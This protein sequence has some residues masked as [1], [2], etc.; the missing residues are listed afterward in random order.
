MDT[1][2][3]GQLYE[4]WC[5]STDGPLLVLAIAFV[6]VLLLPLYQPDLPDA[7]HGA[8]Q[9]ANV[10]LWLA[11]GV[12][13]LTRLGLAPDRRAFARTHVPDLLM[14]AVPFLRPLRLLRVIGLLGSASRRAAERRLVQTTAYVI[15]GVLVLVVVAGGLVLDAERGADN[16]NI[17]SAQDALWWASTTVTTVGYGD[18]FPVTGQGRLVAVA[19]MVGGIALLGVVTASVAAWFVRRFT[20]LET[21]EETAGADARATAEALA[22]V[23]ERLARIEA[24]LE[25]R[26]SG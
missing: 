3:R 7:A 1:A 8:L 25:R 12:D 20:A 24:A 9:V 5:R 22:G 26:A 10:G 4:R 13:Y 14:V 15:G 21:I 16:A 11:F 6:I 19:L 23:T 18:R 17:T 2:H